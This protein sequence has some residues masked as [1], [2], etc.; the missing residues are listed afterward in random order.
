M[1]CQ[2]HSNGGHSTDSVAEFRRGPVD[3]DGSCL[4]RRDVGGGAGQPWQARQASWR[5]VAPTLV[6]PK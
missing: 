4:L 6:K 5:Q 3:H 1:D 2:V